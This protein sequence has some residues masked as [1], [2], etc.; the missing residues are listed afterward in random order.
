M[1]RLFQILFALTLWSTMS[2]SAWAAAGKCGSCGNADWEDDNFLCDQCY[3]CEDCQTNEFLHCFEGC[4]ECGESV[5][6]ICWGCGMCHQC[7]NEQFYH[8]IICGECFGGDP[9]FEC[10]GMCNDCAYE[11]NVH[12]MECGDCANEGA[13]ICD[14]CGMCRICAIEEGAHCEGCNNCFMVDHC[15]TNCYMCEDCQIVWRTHCASCRECYID[16]V[17]ENCDLCEDCALEGHYHCAGCGEC[18]MDE[19]CQSCDMCADCSMN[20][21]T[22]CI[23]CGNCINDVDICDGCGYCIECGIKEGEHCWSCKDEHAECED[24]YLCM[25]CIEDVHAH[26]EQCDGCFYEDGGLCED[27]DL[28]EDCATSNAYHCEQCGE[29]F[30]SEGGI[31]ESCELCVQ[32]A[33]NEGLHCEN[34][35]DNHVECSNG[36]GLCNECALEEGVHCSICEECDPSNTC[37]EGGNHCKNCCENEGWIC[38]NCERCTEGMNVEFCSDCNMCMECCNEMSASNNC[39]HNICVKNEE[40]KNHY[41]TICEKCKTDCE[42]GKTYVAH[43][44]NYVDGVCTICKASKSGKATIFRQP[45]NVNVDDNTS[46]VTFSVLALG[47]DLTYQWYKKTNGVAK[48][49]SDNKNVTGSQENELTISATNAKC[50]DTE[51]YY[52]EIKNVKTV[53]GKAVTYSVTTN[54]VAAIAEHSYEWRSYEWLPETEQ[55]KYIKSVKIEKMNE[56][57][58]SATEFKYSDYHF[59]VCT[60]NGCSAFSGKK[61]NHTYTDWK[62]SVEATEKSKGSRYRRCTVCGADNWE[63]F[64]LGQKTID[65]SIVITKQPSDVKCKVPASTSDTKDNTVT[66]YIQAKGNNLTYQWYLAKYEYGNEKGIE[67]EILVDESPSATSAKLTSGSQTEKLVMSVPRYACYLYQYQVY[68]VVSNGDEEVR[69][70]YANLI[71]DHNML[72]YTISNVGKINSNIEKQYKL[73]QTYQYGTN[74]T[75]TVTYSNYHFLR[76]ASAHGDVKAQSHT[77][78]SW[79]IG[80]YPTATTYGMRYKECKVCGE[81]Y[82]E[83][84]PKTAAGCPIIVTQPKDTR[85]KVN[86]V[87]Y[88][89]MYEHKVT[90][91]VDAIDPEETILSYQWYE[92]EEGETG[93][94]IEDDGD[95]YSGSK[96]SKVTVPAPSNCDGGMQYYC[97]ITNS[98]GKSTKTRYASISTSHNLS[99]VSLI[100]FAD[101]RVGTSYEKTQNS[102]LQSYKKTKTIKGNV[103][104]TNNNSVTKEYCIYHFRGCPGEGCGK[105]DETKERHTYGGWIVRRKP[106]STLYGILERR[107]IYCGESFYKNINPVKDA[108]NPYSSLDNNIISITGASATEDA[109]NGASIK[110]TVVGGMFSIGDNIWVIKEDGSKILRTIV[111]MKVN[112]SDAEECKK[113]DDVTFDLMYEGDGDLY[114]RYEASNMEWSP[115]AKCA[116]SNYGKVQ[117]NDH[118]VGAGSFASQIKTTA[119]YYFEIG[120]KKYPGNF[121]SYGSSSAKDQ[122]YSY[123][124]LNICLAGDGAILYDGMTINVYTRSAKKVNGEITISYTLVGEFTLNG[125]LDKLPENYVTDA[126]GNKILFNEA[127]STITTGVTYI[128]STGTLSLENANLQAIYIG[129]SQINGKSV[130]ISV[131]GNNSI[132]TKEK[133]QAGIYCAGNLT[134]IAKDESEGNQLNVNSLH[135]NGIETP[136]LDISDKSEWKLDVSGNEY[137]I[138]TDYLYNTTSGYYTGI[139]MHVKCNKTS[140]QMALSYTD[141][142]N[143]DMG[144]L[145]SSDNGWAYFNNEK[146]MSINDWIWSIY[147]DKTDKP[148]KEFYTW[149]DPYIII[150]AGMVQA[151]VHDAKEYADNATGTIT[152]DPKTRTLTLD[153]V[154]LSYNGEAISIGSKYSVGD[155]KIKLIG[156]NHFSSNSKQTIYTKGVLQA[157]KNVSIIGDGTLDLVGTGGINGVYLFDGTTLE[158]K[159]KIR[160][161]VSGAKSFTGVNAEGTKLIIGEDVYVDAKNGISDIYDLDLK[162]SGI[163][164]TSNNCDRILYPY[165]WDMNYNE[166]AFTLYYDDT[167]GSSSVYQGDSRVVIGKHYGIKVS[168]F[169]ISEFN[170]N[171][172]IPCFPGASSYYTFDKKSKTLYLH[173]DSDETIYDENLHALVSVYG[174]DVTIVNEENDANFM[175]SDL[176]VFDV[177]KGSLTITGSKKYTFS[178]CGSGEGVINCDQDGVIEFKDANVEFKENAWIGSWSYDSKKSNNIIVSNST[179]TFGDNATIKN[180]KLTLRKEKFDKTG[181]KYDNEM[182]LLSSSKGQGVVDTNGTSKEVTGNFTISPVVVSNNGYVPSDPDLVDKYDQLTGVKD[183]LTEGLDESQ[184]MFNMIGQRVSTDYKGIVVQK[185]KKFLKK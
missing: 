138:K 103:N 90:F 82:Y 133:G 113:G 14:N 58:T 28:C 48:A 139:E 39:K 20:E 18:N 31:C 164:I 146:D 78:G 87:Y 83:S 53:N 9:C 55:S 29:C 100:D 57:S 108:D 124:N 151:G 132:K 125:L 60:A 117:Y 47:D 155:V 45:S 161:T 97:V 12:C 176:A 16:E 115:N 25:S 112:G 1:R 149:R 157:Y 3:C 182:T 141:I 69:S 185:G 121:L 131:K 119:T 99:W 54:E 81:K 156:D 4:G 27:C 175:N 159:D 62:V 166:G 34:C 13:S 26:C 109:S 180:T 32:C 126:N 77:Y 147:D 127:S 96:T 134:L 135:G 22:H 71:T 52:C 144:V 177:Y 130:T 2:V 169:L 111:G 170:E 120:G 38:D 122:L 85:S 102:L 145:F 67:E 86:N 41:C 65:N 23:G 35:E 183:I 162:Y 10:C 165:A 104:N 56:S 30:Y 172:D 70:D 11:N 142:E 44:H 73:T 74:D 118:A 107:C 101:R 63:E 128:A 91:S 79:E 148:T 171:D 94:S 184:P 66:F 143:E 80:T 105:I 129:Q 173:A 152:Y 51:T 6:D 140:G 36:C 68:C 49:L 150:G 174:T 75:K 98:L 93:W 136:Y 19:L 168:N 43:T 89:D 72:T 76:C 40:W 24:C 84:L 59:E 158:F 181:Y 178:D 160:A 179:L 106:T 15:C 153:N 64:S 110:G 42:H 116:V 137:G 46:D 8:C 95:G 92:A 154:N 114:I 21:M 5:G 167:D 123:R 17:C 50:N 88:G 33:I 61:G 163:P 37:E 7:Q